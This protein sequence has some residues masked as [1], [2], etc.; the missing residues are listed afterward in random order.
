VD[1]G[2]IPVQRLNRCFVQTGALAMARLAGLEKQ[3]QFVVDCEF[4]V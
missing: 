3:T 1:A 4:F 2:A